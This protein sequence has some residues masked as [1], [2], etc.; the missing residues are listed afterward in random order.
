M[1]YLELNAKDAIEKLYKETYTLTISENTPYEIPVEGNLGILACGYK[2][3][4]AWRK[5]KSNKSNP[6]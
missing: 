5:L 3:L 1:K 4:I 6:V 2:G